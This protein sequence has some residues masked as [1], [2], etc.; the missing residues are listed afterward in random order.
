MT[1]P[2]T[3][4][5]D[6]LLI[7]YFQK[8]LNSKFHRDHTGHYSHKRIVYLPISVYNLKSISSFEDIEYLE[9]FFLLYVV[10]FWIC[11]LSPELNA[12]GV[13]NEVWTGLNWNLLETIN[14]IYYNI[15]HQFCHLSVFLIFLFLFF[16]LFVLFW[17]LCFYFFLKRIYVIKSR[18]WFPM[19]KLHSMQTESDR[20]LLELNWS[21]QEPKFIVVHLW[22]LIYWLKKELNALWRAWFDWCQV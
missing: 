1:R 7:L 17:F 6:K 21:L 3:V 19:L 11:C 4:Y 12:A 16:F 14:L 22:E 20:L 2:W 15:S 10:W 5:M 8:L 18:N 9:P 13:L